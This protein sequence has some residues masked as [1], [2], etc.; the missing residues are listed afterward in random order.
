V[1][2]KPGPWTAGEAERVRTH[3]YLTERILARPPKLAEVG[4]LAKLHHERIDGSG[5]PQ[6]LHADALPM[7]ARLLAAADVYHALVEARPD[8][9]PLSREQ[10]AETLQGEASAG[11]LDGEAVSAVLTAAGHRVRRRATAP[12]GLTQREVEVLVLL[13]RGLPNKTIARELSISPK[14][15]GTHVE[16]I[17]RKLGVS[18][19]GAA[20][21][22]AMRHGLLAADPLT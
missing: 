16:N 9:P 11:R 5:Y 7:A 4:A 22:I 14:T 6:G 17:Y 10:R 18:T 13:S 2:N 8:R 12:A 15:V 3:P 20:S 19:R 1:W 21:I